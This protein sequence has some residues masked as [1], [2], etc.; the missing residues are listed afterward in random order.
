LSGSEINAAKIIL[1][2]EVTTLL[3]GA[4]AA[5]SA[6]ATARE[7]FEQGGAGGDL[8]TLKVT[9]AEAAD[10]LGIVQ[11][12]VGHNDIDHLVRVDDRAVKVGIAPLDLVDDIH[13]FDDMAH[14]SILAVK[15]IARREHDEELA[16]GGIRVRG[17]R[18]TDDAAGEGNVGKFGRQVGQI[19]SAHP[20]H[21]QVAA[22]MAVLRHRRSGP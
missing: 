7:V 6:E 10:G 11:L 8:P 17:P 14:D 4:E 2:N 19:R 20:G 15:E 18:H 12:F 22:G 16:V 9:A 1:A 3:H 13:P 21:R 5:A